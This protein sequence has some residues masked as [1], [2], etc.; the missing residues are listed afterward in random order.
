M[1]NNRETSNVQVHVLPRIKNLR[2]DQESVASNSVHGTV[3]SNQTTSHPFATKK[4]A[5]Q[6]CHAFVAENSACEEK[7]PNIETQSANIQKTAQGYSKVA[8]WKHLHLDNIMHPDEEDSCS[9]ASSMAPSIKSMKNRAVAP[10][11]RSSERAERRKEFYSKL[12]EKHQALEAEKLQSEAK[13]REEQEAA[14]K[15]LRKNLTF[16]ATPMPSFYHEGPPPKVELKKV[17]PTRARSPKLGRRKSCGDM[18]TATEGENGGWG[19]GRLQRHSL[20]TCKDATNK[21]NTIPRNQNPVNKLKEGIKSTRDNSKQQPT[22]KEI[23]QATSDVA[24]PV[25]PSV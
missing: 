15:Q 21:L 7:Y 12:E 24:S 17:P 23:S 19:R 22:N 13:T 1:D 6:E 8:S 14:L 25:S 10:T 18:N 9:I 11:F 4:H 2:M 20:A 16:R 5:S 3:Q